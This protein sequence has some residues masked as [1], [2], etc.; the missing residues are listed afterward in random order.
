MRL[1]KSVSYLNVTVTKHRRQKVKAITQ[2]QCDE[3]SNIGTVA[4]DISKQRF[5][6]IIN[7]IDAHLAFENLR[8]N[9]VLRCWLCVRAAS[10]RLT[11]FGTPDNVPEHIPAYC[12]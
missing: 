4:D 11:L 10:G 12:Q 8:V 2:T 5:M 7:E 1:G 9:C 6:K 3:K